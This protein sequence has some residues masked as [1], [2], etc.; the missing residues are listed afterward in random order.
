MFVESIPSRVLRAIDMSQ[1]DSTYRI[2]RASI[3]QRRKNLLWSALLS[4]VLVL[5]I[6]FGHSRYPETYNDVLLWSIVGF[7]VLAN[8]VNYVR[9]RRYLR[10]I[11]DH[12]IEVYPGKL[13]FWTGG[14]KTILPIGDIAALALYRKGPALRHIQVRLKNNRGIRLEG[15]EDLEGLAHRL[16]EQVPQAHVIDRKA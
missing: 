12:R 5:V 7:V 14:E 4:L 13:A 15:Y 1:P 9:H 2:S 8:L 6:S 11:R 16:S 10:L 3:A